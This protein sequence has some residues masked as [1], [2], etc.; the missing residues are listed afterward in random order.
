MGTERNTGPDGTGRGNRP[1][2]WD[3]MEQEWNGMWGMPG[4]ERGSWTGK[5]MEWKVGVERYVGMERQGHSGEEGED[6]GAG[7]C[8]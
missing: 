4:T 8:V 6:A 7:L 3:G 2:G 5:G 1:E